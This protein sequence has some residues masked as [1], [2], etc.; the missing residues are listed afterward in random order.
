MDASASH[1]GDALRME[2]LVRDVETHEHAARWAFRFLERA[3]EHERFPERPGRDERSHAEPKPLA[4]EREDEAPDPTRR[5]H[6]STHRPRREPVDDE[7]RIEGRRPPEDGAPKHRRDVDLG[8]ELQRA[9]PRFTLPEE[10]A[11]EA[12]EPATA[13]HAGRG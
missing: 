1:R 2:R 9:K 13:R 11:E 7:R 6:D 4:L 3:L 5:R 12:D 10:G 8:H